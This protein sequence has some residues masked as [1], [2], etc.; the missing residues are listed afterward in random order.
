MKK[1][2]YFLILI[3]ILTFLPDT[4]S[5]QPVLKVGALVPF[6]GRW[7]DSGRECAKG[8]LDASKWVNQRGGVFGRKLDVVLIDDPSQAGET[9]AAFRKLNEADRI[10]LFYVFSLDTALALVPH[11]HY[12]RIPT[13]VASLPTSLADSVQ[14]PY[15]FS[16]TPTP[17]DLGKIAMKF[18]AENPGPKSKK[19]R[20]IFMGYPDPLSRDSLDEVK[21]YGNALGLDAKIDISIS[22]P[23]TPAGISSVLSTLSSYNPD[24]VFLS[25]T[26]KEAFF[27]LQEAARMGS[28]PRWIFSAKAFD[29]TLSSFEGILGVQPVSPF[30]EDVPGMGDLK[31]AHQRWHPLDSHTVFYVEGWATVRII[32]EAL[33]RSLPE[34][35]L[36]REMVKNSLEGFKDFMMGGI[37]PPV[38]LTANDHRASVESR[39]FTMKEG[40]MVRQSGFISVGR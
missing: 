21:K 23:T 17:R 33:G 1:I 29:E 28:K 4:G 5:A 31:E 25:G 34:Q 30:G 6:S 40:K 32:A 2:L 13:L 14:Y 8:I 24:F 26:S 27:V 18:I 39:I 10:L 22:D 20:V 16:P 36:S 7:G 19:P 38:T 9:L 15:V 37:L 35:K 3:S 12:H 11:I